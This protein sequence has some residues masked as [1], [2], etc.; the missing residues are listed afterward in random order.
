[1]SS[2]IRARGLLKQFGEQV[3][4]D[5][6]DFEVGAGERVALLGPN[7][8]GKTTLFRCL[9]G[10]ASFDGEL[11]VADRSVRRHGKEARRRIG[12]VPQTAPVYDTTLRGFL[13]LFCDL[14]GVD[15]DGPASRLA[16]L[17]LPLER[18]GD[19][20]L[21]ELSG[22]M[23]QK[24][25]LA[26]ALGSEAP[27]LLLDEPTASLDPG[28][29]REF[30]RAVRAVEVDRTLVFASHRFDE[31]DTLADRVLVLH[32]GR[33]VFDGTPSEFWQR[34]GTGVELWLRV[35]SEDRELVADTIRGLSAVRHVHSNG[36]GL[37]VRVE[38]A[39]ELELLGELRDRNLPILE[40]R[41]RPPAPDEV[42]ARVLE[43]SGGG[44]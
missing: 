25:V 5:E 11:V 27:L 20:R 14:R 10:V 23:L 44:P 29:R 2:L 40:F 22:G 42:M 39:R 32:R 6:L 37:E 8:A 43:A 34:A 19:K 3:V 24:A 21:R 41:S 7:G 31:I 28:S 36:R 13:D 33:F 16:D 17:G 4:L 1:M 9:L 26:L 18:E 15:R 30:L 12:Y 38:A 35:P